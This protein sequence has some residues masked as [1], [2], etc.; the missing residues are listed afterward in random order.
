M[1]IQNVEFKARVAALE[2][3]EKQLLSLGAKLVAT[4]HQVDT[5]FNTSEARLKLRESGSQN[6]L[7]HYDRADTSTAKQSDIIYYQHLPNTALKSILTTHLG[8]K[9]I[10]DKIRT[11]YAIDN[12]RFHLD[13]VQQLGTFLEVEAMDENQNFTA[14]ALKDQCDWYF[15][16]FKLNEVDLVN[17]S[18]SDLILAKNP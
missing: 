13:M 4:E 14:T 7:I 12:V 17:L 11:I 18:Y 6:S 8:V 10:V 2:P 16:L 5:Y 9:V 15:S 1:K 3:F